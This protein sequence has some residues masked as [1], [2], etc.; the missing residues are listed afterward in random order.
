M[1]GVLSIDRAL[2]VVELLPRHCRRR[3]NCEG[4]SS[5]MKVL[6]MSC[7]VFP[8]GWH[9]TAICYMS[10]LSPILK[11]CRGLRWFTA[12]IALL[13]V[14]N[15]AVVRLLCYT[16]VLPSNFELLRIKVR[17]SLNAVYRGRTRVCKRDTCSRYSVCH[18]FS[19]SRFEL[20]ITTLEI[21]GWDWWLI[22]KVQ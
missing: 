21:P 9:S 6:S 10:Y 18:C 13:S 2:A 17:K 14:E 5:P 15:I 22:V 3:K 12:G 19:V 16:L 7:L 1:V 4:F 20:G 11:L 8:P